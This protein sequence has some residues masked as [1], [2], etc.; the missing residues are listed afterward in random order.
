M[1]LLSLSVDFMNDFRKIAIGLNKTF[2]GF[3]KDYCKTMHPIAYNLT[4]DGDGFVKP[5]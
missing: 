4:G 5:E 1:P 2:D 3:V